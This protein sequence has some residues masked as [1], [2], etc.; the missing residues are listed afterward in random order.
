MSIVGGLLVLEILLFGIVCYICYEESKTM[1]EVYLGGLP[2]CG[3]NT[4]SNFLD[5]S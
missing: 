2:V 1:V 4:E 5:F 3:R